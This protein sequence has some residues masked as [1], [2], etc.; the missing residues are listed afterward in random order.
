VTV[1]EILEQ[2]L[3]K[4][5]FDGLY[6]EDHCGCDLEDLMPCD[7]PSDQCMPGFYQ[8]QDEDGIHLMGPQSHGI[9]KDN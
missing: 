7:G 1:K 4:R 8:A 6:L 3:K 2:H 9:K 5:G